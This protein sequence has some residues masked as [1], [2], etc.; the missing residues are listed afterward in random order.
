M[1]NKRILIGITDSITAYKIVTLVRLLKESGAEVKVVMTPESR[2]F[3]TSSTMATV[4]GNPIY[5][6]TS[7]LS[8]DSHQELAQWAHIII[9]APASAN[10]ISKMATGIADNLLLTTYFSTTRPVTIAPEC[11]LDRYEHPTTKENMKKLE[12]H[13]VYIIQ[14]T[15]KKIANDQVKLIS[16]AEP[17][18]IANVIKS[19]LFPWG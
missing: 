15:E 16:M 5:S 1:Q 11:D 12:E 9:I 3:V 4:S 8:S 10:T 13:G 6:D 17:E 18:T 19:L 14:P 2:Q 7:E